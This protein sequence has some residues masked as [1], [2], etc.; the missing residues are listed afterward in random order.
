MRFERPANGLALAIGVVLAMVLVAGCQRPTPTATQTPTAALARYRDISLQ[1]IAPSQVQQY[2]HVDGLDILL[3]N[4]GD[5]A[6][7]SHGCGG[8]MLFKVFD[9]NGNEVWHSS[10]WMLPCLAHTTVKHDESVSISTFS[11]GTVSWDLRDQ[12]GFP[13][14]PG[15]Y[16]V[17]GLFHQPATPLVT[18]KQRL[19]VLPAQMPAYAKQIKLDITAPAAA[20]AG[21][22]IPMDLRLTNTGNEPLTYW[23]S[24]TNY[25]PRLNYVNI[26]VIKDGE[27]IWSTIDAHDITGEGPETLAPS[28]EKAVGSLF[29][30]TWT[31]DLHADCSGGLSRYQRCD[32]PVE[33]GTYTVR[34]EVNVSPPGTQDQTTS[35]PPERTAVSVQQTLV[36]EP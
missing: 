32:T 12:N 18:P 24:G 21:D 31:W 15:D 13:V 20:K 23:W 34:A 6:T 27:P 26:V 9:S 36:V 35:S 22:T 29:A 17:Q 25:A 19:T 16:T 4:S 8:D 30:Q 5:A 14:P 7:F 3:T 1:L 10:D 11:G 2:G 28:E 33:P